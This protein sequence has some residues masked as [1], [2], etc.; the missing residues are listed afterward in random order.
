MQLEGIS[1]RFYRGHVCVC[2]LAIFYNFIAQD[3]EGGP[4][5]FVLLLLEQER[6]ASKLFV[7]EVMQ[8]F[9]EKRY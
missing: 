8:A 9:T 6:R 3:S 2:I 5:E 7:G 4:S 1:S